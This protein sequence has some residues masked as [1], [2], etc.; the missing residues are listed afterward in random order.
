[1]TVLGEIVS[2]SG[3]QS[4]RLYVFY[5]TFM[6]EGWTFEDQNSYEM[7]NTVRDEQDEINRR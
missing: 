5:D 6:T 1:V 3:F 2:A 7:S 4:E